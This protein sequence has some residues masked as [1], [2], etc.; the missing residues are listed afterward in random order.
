MIWPLWA[1]V[2]SSVCVCGSDN[3]TAQGCSE[4]WKGKVCAAEAT[5]LLKHKSD[6]VILFYNLPLDQRGIKM[7]LPH[8]AVKIKWGNSCTALSRAS[9]DSNDSPQK[10]GAVVMMLLIIMMVNPLRIGTSQVTSPLS[11]TPFPRTGWVG[12]NLSPFPFF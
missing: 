2:S 10:L 11:T 3:H 8:G 12:E 1:S 5:V 9:L 7:V 6:H 4:G